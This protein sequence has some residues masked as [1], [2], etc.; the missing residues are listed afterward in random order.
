MRFTFS[1][2]IWLAVVFLSESP[3]IAAK[4]WDAAGLPKDN[5]A[6]QFVPPDAAQVE[7]R[8]WEVMSKIPH[9]RMQK[10]E[11]DYLSEPGVVEGLGRLLEFY[12]LCY[13]YFLEAEKG[14]NTS[15]FA[16]E[17]KLS[18]AEY[19]KY[20]RDFK[21]LTHHWKIDPI[22]S[23]VH[24]TDTL[25]RI[26]DERALQILARGFFFTGNTKPV[27]DDSWYSPPESWVESDFK[28]IIRKKR[29]D[30]YLTFPKH[31]HTTRHKD[32]YDEVRKWILANKATLLPDGVPKFANVQEAPF[33]EYIAKQEAAALANPQP[34][35][36]YPGYNGVRTPENRRRIL[37]TLQIMGGILL[38]WAVRLIWKKAKNR[39]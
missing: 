37:I 31:D 9:D 20:A 18:S 35:E 28:Y 39:G 10:F 12:S 6:L 16:V 36:E 1:Y 29:P 4:R 7:R 5:A 34:V 8:L 24:L 3:A 25:Q 2:F 38:L 19:R 30:L 14:S 32:Y 11:S 15:P 22:T 23:L 26:G 33:L 17:Q 13:V 27:G 21:Y